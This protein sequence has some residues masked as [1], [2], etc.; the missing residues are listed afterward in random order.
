[1]RTNRQKIL[2]AVLAL[3]ILAGI[4]FAIP[5]IRERVM[6]RVDQL[7]VS[8]FYRFRP[9]E[10]EVFVPQEAQARPTATPT[11]APTFTSTPEEPEDTPTPQPTPTP[12]PGEVS[13]DGVVYTDQHGL[14]NY[15]A[16]A[17][18]AMQLSF[19][20]WEGDRVD[21]GT[22]VK[23]FEKDKNVMAYELSDYVT[24]QTDLQSALRYG[25]TLEL[26]K[27]LI[28][29]GYP[30]LI[31]KGTYI[32]E[33]STGKVSWMG[34]YNVITG[35]SDET[36]EFIVQDSYYTPDY[37]IAYDLLASEWRAFNNVFVVV[38]PPD[39]QDEVFEILGE[40]ADPEQ[41]NRIAAQI[42]SDEIYTLSGVDKF[43]AWFN[44]GSSLVNLQ[45]Y[46]GAAA[47]YDE[48][49]SYYATLPEEGR[50]WRITW[51]QTGPYFAYFYAGRYQDV[52]NLATQTI[53][54]AVEPYLEENF[55]WRARA[56]TALGDFDSAVQDLRTSLEYHPGF[57]PSV[58]FLRELGYSE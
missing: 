43:F 11:I 45:D 24:E 16:P 47:A 20:G 7:R 36:E 5:P 55:Y 52:V 17:N 12:L 57:T 37:R 32:R 29:N 8:L 2:L 33:T 13:I 9:P 35:Y 22:Y 49:W 28:A 56:Y 42:A 21:I 58:T 15:C 34:H 18:L 46:Y 10:K 23:P 38:Y 54:G 44:R 50:P 27:A 25:G 30:V 31:E 1:M 6:W 40:Y 53:D 14:W 39:K 3:V 51:Y 48:A 19:W 26:A 4:L 41:S